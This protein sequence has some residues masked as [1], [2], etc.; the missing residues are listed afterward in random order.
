MICNHAME[1][2]FFLEAHVYCT[3]CKCSSFC[4]DS[5]TFTSYFCLKKMF[6]RQ[7]LSVARSSKKDEFYTLYEDVK[8]ELDHYLDQFKDKVIYCPCDTEESAF[9]KYFLELEAKGLIK[10][11]LYTSLQNGT[12]FLSDGAIDGYKHSDIIV[13]NPPFS[14]FRPFI[15]L[16]DSLNKQFI[17]W[18]NN[19]A[20]CYKQVSSMLV[21]DKIRLGYIANKTCE[22][23]VPEEYGADD[24]SSKVYLRNNKHYVKVAAITTF[25]NLAVNRESNLELTTKYDPSIHFKYDNFDAI[26]CNKVSIIP[27]DYDGYIGVPVTYLSKH[28]PSKFKIVGIFNNFEKLDLDAGRVTGELV[29]VGTLKT[30]GPCVNGLPVYVRLI[31]QRIKD[32]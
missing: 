18:S 27:Y 9:V 10:E 19:N 31:I 22:F 17:V 5:I 24:P 4:S 26:N 20:I 29:H 13:T 32:N 8:F 12:N 25:T 6:T 28:D 2:R 21:K 16:L 30:R 7:R 15:S 11:L 23:E 3:T 14:L 1:V